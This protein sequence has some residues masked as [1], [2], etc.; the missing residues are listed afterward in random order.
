MNEHPLIESHERIPATRRDHGHVTLREHCD[1]KTTRVVSLVLGRT[2]I[3]TQPH[4][5][6]ELVFDP[7]PISHDPLRRSAW[8]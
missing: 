6:C 7:L 1:R 8:L 3:A 4:K 5:R 2:G